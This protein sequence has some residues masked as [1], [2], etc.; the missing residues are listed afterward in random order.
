MVYTVCEYVVYA[1][2]FYLYHRR[3]STR[4]L[5]TRKPHK[6]YYISIED[7]GGSSSITN[8]A[9]YIIAAQLGERREEFFINAAAYSSAAA[10][11]KTTAWM[12]K[13]LNG[14]TRPHGRSIT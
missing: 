4:A 7:G 3:R 13:R 6:V 5:H 1:I 14:R 2:L 9:R 11:L 12:E 10:V 8:T